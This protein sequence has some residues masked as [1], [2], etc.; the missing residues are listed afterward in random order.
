[1][2]HHPITALS[3]VVRAPRIFY[4]WWVALVGAGFQALVGALFFHGFGTFF[5]ALQREFG[6]SRTMLSGAYSFARLEGGLLGPVE[7]FFIDRLGPRR[8]LIVGLAL[9]TVGYGLFSLTNTPAWFYASFLVLALGFSLAGWLTLSAAVNNWFIR[10]RATAAS[11]LGIGLSVGGLLVPLLALALERW[12]WRTTSVGAGIFLLIVGVPMA[13]LV[14]RRP[15]DFGLLPDGAPHPPTAR[16]Q[17]PPPAEPDFSLRQAVRTRAFW[18]ISLGHSVALIPTNAV[19]V[20]LVPF[21]YNEVDLPLAVAATVVTVSTAVGIPAQLAGGLVGDRVDKR[22]ALTVLTAGQGVA[23]LVLAV[24][25]SLAVAMLFGVLHGV[26]WGARAPFTTA[27]R[28]DYFGRRAFATI[29]G[30]MNLI[31]TLGTIA[32]PLFV[33]YVADRVGYRL[34]FVVVAVVT[35]IGSLCFLAARRPTPSPQAASG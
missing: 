23:L 12:G 21:L 18:A 34:A 32:G 31:T 28:G 19:V 2:A 7:G 3:R 6:W 15:E 24:T 13:L 14:R 30:S 20:H 22:I 16:G 4:G 27:I 29:S 33:G 9:C 8:M 35:V 10:R 1:M 17:P 26:A 25:H 5:V 11:L